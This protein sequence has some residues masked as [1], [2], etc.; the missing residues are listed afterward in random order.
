MGGAFRLRRA[1][2]ERSIGVVPMINIVFL[3]LVFFLLTATIAPPDPV[4]LDLPAA[5]GRD[6][7]DLSEGAALHVTSDGTVALGAL[8]GAAVFDALAGWPEGDVLVVRADA[9][10]DG[11]V[12]AGLLSRLRL[13]GVGE[14]SVAVRRPDGGVPRSN[15]P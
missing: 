13:I 9:G 2:R 14:V 6:P 5:E 1:R 11:T 4:E 15:S 3:L 10:L 7:P 8:R 12:F